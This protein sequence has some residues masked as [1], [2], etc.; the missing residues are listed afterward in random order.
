[1]ER[2]I[3]EERYEAWLEAEARGD[4]RISDAALAALFAELPLEAPSPG[5]ASATLAR[6]RAESRA[7]RWAEAGAEA[8]PPL[9][10]ARW[11]AV[12][13][14]LLSAGTLGLS[15]FAVNILPKLELG[16]AV[17]VFNSVVAATWEWIAS[18]ITLWVRLAEWSDLVA[19]VV[20]VPGVAWTLLGAAAA[21]V[22]AFSLLRRILQHDLQEKETIHVRHH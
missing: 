18:G 11:A 22:F 21:A 1:M 19:R 16:A 7:E 13:L 14:A 17:A 20:A 15:A 5:F 2:R 3:H 4:E 8:A 9:G 6:V 12:V 10:A